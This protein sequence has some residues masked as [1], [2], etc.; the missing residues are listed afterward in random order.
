MR[1]L[2]LL[3]LA[4]TACAPKIAPQPAAHPASL[5]WRDRVD[6]DAAGDEAVQMLAR[7]LRIDT[8][9]APGNEA[10]GARYLAD[11][12]ARDGIQA[13]LVGHE[14]GREGLIARVRA[15]DPGEDPL[16]LLS[17][18]DVV[19]AEDE[20]WPD[21]FGPLSGAID[22]EGMLW[23]RGAL[24]MKSLGIA[25]LH[26]LALLVRLGVPLRRDVILLAVADEEMDN[27]GMLHLVQERWD[28]LS[29]GH[30]LNEG[31]FGVRGALYDD[32][33]V[34]AV[35]VGEKGVLWVDV[36]ATGEPGHGSTPL[37]DSSLDRLRAAIDSIDTRRVKPNW[38]PMMLEL[39][40]RA[41]DAGGGLT[42]YV[43]QRPGLVK[44]L[45]RG[46]L[47]DNPVTW[48][49]LTTTVHLTGL[50]GAVSPNVLPGEVRATYDIRKQPGHTTQQVLDELAELTRDI[51]GISFEVRSDL[52]AAISPYQ[53]DPFYDAI[54]AHALEGRGPE[55]V[56]GPLLSIGFTDSVF[57]RREGTIAY[58]YA[59]FVID[60]DL[61]TSMHGHRERIPVDQVVEGS[62]RLFGMVVQGAAD[63]Q[64][65]TDTPAPGPLVRPVPEPRDALPAAPTQ[66]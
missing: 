20:V 35:S 41:G 19:P 24:D 64:A 26:A 49:S 55:H 36:I 3:V 25:E 33:V 44:L 21:G 29:C 56:A 31:G 12:L 52:P 61:L 2:I 62:R 38:H 40:A 59:P 13:E 28:E 48:A 60:P 16:C 32:Q 17:H 9:N 65:P 63:L 22:D 66:E 10:R 6:W 54:I 42:G 23:G 50:D 18:I 58:G 7:Y 34:H 39:L 27:L 15:Q 46:T 14:Q 53:D 11:L 57:A 37:G 8:I 51:E 45:A 43:L 30:I 4:L 47:K 1:L 5:A